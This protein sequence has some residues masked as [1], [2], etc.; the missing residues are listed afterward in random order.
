[1]RRRSTFWKY[2]IGV[3]LSDGSHDHSAVAV[4]EAS[5]DES[6]ENLT[7]GVGKP[8]LHEIIALRRFDLT[9]KPEHIEDELLVFLEH[10]LFQGSKTIMVVETNSIG[11][12]VFRSLS[13]RGLSVDRLMGVEVTGGHTEG[14]MSGGI[15]PVP[16]QNL[17]QPLRRAVELG[18]LKA[19]EG[20]TWWPA[21]REELVHYQA[22]KTA[23]GRLSYG[24]DETRTAHDDLVMAAAHAWYAGTQLGSSRELRVVR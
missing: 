19:R 21:M 18:S 7:D 23:S 2:R 16:K 5:V 14:V 11:G 3:D 22:R 1:M 4:I 24:N 8:L 20:L 6:L 15:K 9:Y 12:R 10:P 13:S 17:V